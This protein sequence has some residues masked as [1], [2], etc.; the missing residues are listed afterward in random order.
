M[1]RLIAVS[2][3]F[4]VTASFASA[5][6]WDPVA[7]LREEWAGLSR[8][9]LASRDD[10]KRM[11]D[12]A[13]IRTEFADRELVRLA[14][15]IVVS[16]NYEDQELMERQFWSMGSIVDR[17]R[18]KVTGLLSEEDRQDLLQTSAVLVRVREQSYRSLREQYEGIARAQGID[19][20]VIFVEDLIP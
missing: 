20:R 13:K 2:F 7:D 14:A 1:K 10:L 4:G 18:R 19:P 16:P 3:L 12:V 15:R 9:Y 5:G 11:R 6:T 8:T 17:L